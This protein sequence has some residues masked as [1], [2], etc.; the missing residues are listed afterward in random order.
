V[1][2]ILRDKKA[3]AFF[4]APAAIL[5]ILILVGPILSAVYI[6]L[7][8]WDALSSPKFV[9]FEN[10]IKMFTK[11]PQIHIAIKNTLFIT[12]FS[13]V[14]QQAIGLG[15]AA[16][17]SSKIKASNVFKNTYYLP[18]VLS[19]AAIGLLFS[20]IFNPGMGINQL[21]LK[22][23]IKGPLWLMD[24]SGFITLPMITIGIVATWQYM[25]QTMMLYM[26][27]ITGI[28]ESLSEAAKIDGATGLETFRYITLPLIKPMTKVSVSLTCIGSLKFFDLIWNMTKG[29]PS[30][31][32]EVLSSL[33]Y[34]DAF[35][36]FKYGY[37]SA[38]SIT[39]T[40]L[41]LLVTFIVNKCIKAEDYEM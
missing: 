17:L 32:T 2:K 12:L 31:N 24:V 18:C 37:A 7:C 38:I 26:A 34:A 1:E 22:I 13:L 39:L 11:D 40:V 10:Y 30:H 20:F 25:G 8:N 14:T 16:L 27:A 36:Y 41:C 19:S 23:G 21:L 6:S 29:G 35:K 15:L 4:V 5:F 3:I 28:P 33:V 9:G